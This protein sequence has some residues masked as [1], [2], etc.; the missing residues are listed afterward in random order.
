MGQCCNRTAENLEGDGLR[1]AGLNRGRRGRGP[2]LI[3][4]I[5]GAALEGEHLA[6]AEPRLQHCTVKHHAIPVTL[7]YNDHCFMQ[8]PV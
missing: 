5:E 7:Q 2:A 3:G 8:T 6:L 1:S 4:E